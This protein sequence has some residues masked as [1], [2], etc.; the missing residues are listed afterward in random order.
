[1]CTWNHFRRKQTPG[2]AS[3]TNPCLPLHEPSSVY[4]FFTHS[5]GA[6][7]QRPRRDFRERVW[8][9]CGQQVSL[10]LVKNIHLVWHACTALP[11]FVLKVD[12]NTPLAGSIKVPQKSQQE[13]VAGDPRFPVLPSQLRGTTV[14]LMETPGPKESGQSVKLSLCRAGAGCFAPITTRN[15]FL[16]H[17]HATTERAEGASRPCPKALANRLLGWLRAT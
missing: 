3:I 4:I 13:V 17:S 1:M 8:V 16:P 15:K 9:C 7:G 2:D 14:Q 6:P 12:S 5:V 11:L 10:S